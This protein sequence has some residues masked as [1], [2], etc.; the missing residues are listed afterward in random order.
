VLVVENRGSEPVAVS[1]RGEVRA[2]SPRPLRLVD[3]GLRMQVLALGT[4]WTS[5][6]T[7]DLKLEP[8]ESRR[9]AFET[10]QPTVRAETDD[11]R[12]LAFAVRSLTVRV[13]PR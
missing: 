2:L 3:R 13:R 12:T 7:A 1:L 6:E 4:A 5:F 11:P 9:I 8:G 10:D